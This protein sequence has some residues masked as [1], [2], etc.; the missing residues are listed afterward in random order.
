MKRGDS[1]CYDRVID[2]VKFQYSYDNGQ[3]WYDHE[4]GKWFPTGQA[5]TDNQYVVRKIDIS[6]PMHGN[7]FRVVIDRFH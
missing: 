5:L 7:A 1:C 6:P 3:T 2:A 4:N